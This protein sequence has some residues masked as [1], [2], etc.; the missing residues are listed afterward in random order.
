[1]SCFVP[2]ARLITEILSSAVLAR[3]GPPKVMEEVRF[4]PSF[5][6]RLGVL[7]FSSSNDILL[8]ITNGVCLLGSR[9]VRNN[10]IFGAKLRVKNILELESI[11]RV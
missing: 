6:P 11:L 7:F 2:L 5:G 9:D 4:L 3:F 10:A 8:D 1:M